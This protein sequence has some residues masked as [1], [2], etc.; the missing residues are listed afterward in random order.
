MAQEVQS[1]FKNVKFQFV[2]N[3]ARVLSKMKDIFWIKYIWYTQKK[4]MTK[5][6]RYSG[7]EQGGVL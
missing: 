1:F 2:F 3:L 4:N 7:Q 5:N 6:T